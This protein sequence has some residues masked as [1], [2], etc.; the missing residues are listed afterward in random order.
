MRT[1][2][3]NRDKNVPPELVRSEQMLRMEWRSQPVRQIGSGVRIGDNLVCKQCHYDHKNNP[4]RTGDDGER[5][6]AVLMLSPSVLCCGRR[7][8]REGH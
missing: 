3:T 4:E 8:E 1:E 2:K 7:P 6:P 5:D